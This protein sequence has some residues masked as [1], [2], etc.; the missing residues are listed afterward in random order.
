MV[1]ECCG[2]PVLNANSF[3]SVFFYEN[4]SYWDGSRID[5]TPVVMTLLD[6]NISK[7]L[8]VLA[9]IVDVNE[10]YFLKN[11][12]K[13][14]QFLKSLQL[15]PK[16]SDFLSQEKLRMFMI[17]YRKLC[18]IYVYIFEVLNRL[19][20]L[21]F[22]KLEDTSILRQFRAKNAHFLLLKRIIAQQMIATN[23]W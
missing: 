10:V 21:Y 11:L 12:S 22:I 4:M 7:F 2:S 9:V 5:A 15:F 23:K 18:F 3:I 6:K 20:T 14:R 8:W 16:K 13:K 17:F 19:V 1:P